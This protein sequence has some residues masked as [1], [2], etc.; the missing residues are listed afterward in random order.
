MNAF[1]PIDKSRGFRLF[2]VG[3]AQMNRHKR[4]LKKIQTL[5]KR[6]YFYCPVTQHHDCSS[7][8]HE[9]ILVSC[10]QCTGRVYECSRCSL[11]KKD[12]MRIHASHDNACHW[13][14]YASFGPEFC[15]CGED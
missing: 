15:F 9:F 14:G 1:I 10:D 11:K 6:G 3:K 4:K 7:G 13:P 5:K 12:P 2:S 8:V